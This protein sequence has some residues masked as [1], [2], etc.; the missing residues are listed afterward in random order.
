M[1]RTRRYKVRMR[2]SG[3][4]QSMPSRSPARPLTSPNIVCRSLP[5]QCRFP[6]SV[7]DPNWVGL[8]PSILAELVGHLAWRRA[9]ESAQLFLSVHSELRWAGRRDGP[10][11]VAVLTDLLSRQRPCRG[12]TAGA[13]CLDLCRHRW[14][15]CAS[16]PASDPLHPVGPLRIEHADCTDMHRQAG[17]CAIELDFGSWV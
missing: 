13:G 4:E 9:P 6:G 8:E 7:L 3:L 14:L 15:C 2:P 12:C 11:A 1:A 10:V 16:P 17:R 5:C